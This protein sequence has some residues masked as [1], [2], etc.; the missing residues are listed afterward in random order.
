[1]VI[2]GDDREVEA[3]VEATE[4]IVGV[5]EVGATVLLVIATIVIA[6]VETVAGVVIA[7]SG[8]AD[9]V[10]I[11]EGEIVPTVLVPQVD[12]AL[13]HV[14]RDHRGPQKVERVPRTV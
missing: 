5:T 2:P 10:G 3:P 12:L 9:T 13:R 14:L 4:G 6:T 8:E 1:M 7:V 11:R